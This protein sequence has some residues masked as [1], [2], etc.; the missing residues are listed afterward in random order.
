MV[1]VLIRLIRMGMIRIGMMGKVEISGFVYEGGKVD[2]VWEF[3]LKNGNKFQK[4]PPAKC[5]IFA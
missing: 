3:S 2:S 4:P 1:E 5:I